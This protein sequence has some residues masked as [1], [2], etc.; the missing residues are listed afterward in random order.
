[1]AQARHCRL[2]QQSRWSEA[3]NGAVRF[4]SEFCMVVPLSSPLKAQWLRLQCTLPVTQSSSHHNCYCYCYKPPNPQNCCS[5]QRLLWRA[6]GSFKA[7]FSSRL[8]PCDK[9]QPGPGLGC[10]PAFVQQ[11]WTPVMSWP[12]TTCG[13]CLCIIDTGQSFPS[14]ATE[15]C[16]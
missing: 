6:I 9:L 8:D 12:P 11:T 4:E 13:V 10:L 16:T 2:L 1:M 15:Q 7:G 5:L 14:R 3:L